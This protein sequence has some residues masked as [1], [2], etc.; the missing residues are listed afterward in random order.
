MKKLI[1]TTLLLLYSSFSLSLETKGLTEGEVQY[2]SNTKVLKVAVLS[3]NNDERETVDRN[4]E[5]F[6]ITIDYMRG[7]A[8][9]LGINLD[10]VNYQSVSAVYD[11]VENKEVDLAAGF[12]PTLDRS[13][14]FVFTAPL[15]Q[16]S[17]AA[18]YV[19]KDKARRDPANLHWVCV[20]GTVYCSILE[21]N[22]FAKIK[23]ESSFFNA[24]QTLNKGEADAIYE[25]YVSL[26]EYMKDSN[27]QLDKLTIPFWSEPLDVAAFT[28]TD[29]PQI[30]SI[31]NK[32]IAN[33][34]AGKNKFPIT[35]PSP[36]HATDKL[37]VY[38]KN[39]KKFLKPLKYTIEDDIYP[40]FYKTSSGHYTGFVKDIIE[41][42]E[43]RTNLKFEYVPRK[44]GMTSEQMLKEG[45]IDLL[46]LI[47]NETK[48]INL[49]QLSK[50][51]IRLKYLAMELKDSDD[52]SKEK[53]GVLLA[54][55]H[56]KKYMDSLNESSF[57]PNASYYFDF[58][59]VVEALDNHEIG[60]AFVSE[61]LVDLIIA[62]QVDERFKIN[63]K[64]YRTINI[65]MGVSSDDPML[66]RVLNS[67]LATF[68]E[69]ELNKL[70]RNYTMFNVNYGYDKQGVETIAYI[71]LIVLLSLAVVVCFAWIRLKGEVTLSTTEAKHT[72]K[73]LE[74][75]Q[76]IIN[77]LPVQVFIHDH[78]QKLIL[79]NC[80]EFR[81]GKCSQCK[82]KSDDD[83]ELVENFA[84]IKRVFECDETVSRIVDINNCNLDMSSVHYF[85]KKISHKNS[86]KQLV[87]T[88]INDITT[89]REQELKLI[90]ASQKANESVI[91]R[92]RFLASMSHE[93]RTPIA[94]MSGL[95]EMLKLK[96]ND[97]ESLVIIENIES[98]T[99]NLHLLVNDI[100]DF[101]KLE[102][103]QLQI[104]I[105][106]TNIFRE[107]GKVI[108]N[109]SIAA[110][111]K[112]L[113]FDI[114]WE[115]SDCCEYFV[116]SLRLSQIMNNLLSNAI[117]FTAK[118]SIRVSIELQAEKLEVSVTDTGEG[119]TEEQRQKVFDPFVQAD[120]STA[121]RF[122]GTGL[123]LTIV[124]KLVEMMNGELTIHSALGLGTKV[125]F[126]FPVEKDQRR[127]E[128]LPLQNV[129]YVGD[130]RLV[131]SWV[132]G[133]QIESEE[134][135]I[136]IYDRKYAKKASA[137]ES[138]AIVLCPSVQDFV[139]RTGEV[140]E[141][142]SNP[143]YPDLIFDA[144][145]SHREGAKQLG[146][147]ETRKMKG[148][149][150]VA[151]DNP[152]NRLLIEK[153]LR[154]LG[155]SAEIVNDGRAALEAIRERA[156]DFDLLI[157][158]C[159][160]PFVDGFE[161][162]RTIR[163][164]ISVFDSKAIIGCTAADARSEMQQN[165]ALFDDLLFK[166]YGLDML[167]RIVSKHL[168]SNMTSNSEKRGKALKGELSD[169]PGWL[170]NIDNS[171]QAFMA[172]VFI[173]SIESDLSKLSATIETSN[174]DL[175][176]AKSIA[177]RVK[178]GAA[179][180][181]AESILRAAK[182]VESLSSDDQQQ[183]VQ[184]ITELTHAMEYE[185]E[186]VRKWLRKNEN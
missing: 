87:L 148:H 85:R 133:E 59:D 77:G 32:I 108:R 112:G 119:M 19:S 64:I 151:E 102:A 13:R 63:N 38:L 106:P 129:K 183:H 86:N 22:G 80:E 124:K 146:G 40:M 30:V 26:I 5:F 45:S 74:F 130:N 128:M 33:E 171:E 113:N 46:P 176:R 110:K 47:V 23:K 69:F 123:G 175:I 65:S 159:H 28:A 89:Q 56:E 15:F 186:L 94:G 25:S 185:L 111:D 164:E 149:V 143:I 122:G 75:L 172:K 103:E 52:V 144:L 10:I 29:N 36:Y 109:H 39:E 118:G 107:L 157:T 54:D 44:D 162:A 178:G 61:H 95:L 48:D 99:Q 73:E 12:T 14:R 156:S 125:S 84:E 71:G 78:D 92:E 147:T 81:L 168:E 98:S 150:L 121:R 163:N 6:D 96:A 7:I 174:T 179:V 134:P 70:K 91:A 182:D 127:K 43:D 135:L 42:V 104:D 97:D 101:S 141:V 72:Q 8:N 166:P 100:L 62:Q 165:D 57:G 169:G 88:A 93:L 136:V 139:H 160:M 158:D 76:S 82:M 79:T 181:G 41:L 18:G 145:L 167:T 184:L 114:D 132:S 50:P 155:I 17:A 115:F 120:S 53:V 27:V 126:W 37:S 24:V 31:I 138:K 177:H 60:R 20:E 116:D 105:N 83:D 3:E 2:L 16:S 140:I 173:D 9:V 67:T 55:E 152:I 90:D 1:V 161:L 4:D 68:D 49:I 51:Y 58:N 131:R 35:S 137:V 180:V 117:K 21:K 154:E 170:L 153:Q 11:A 66:L 34:L 142:S